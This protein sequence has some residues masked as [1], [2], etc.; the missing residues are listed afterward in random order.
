MR[1]ALKDVFHVLRPLDCFPQPAPPPPSPEEVYQAKAKGQPIATKPCPLE[2]LKHGA[3]SLERL[4]HMRTFTV[5]ELRRK[6]QRVQNGVQVLDLTVLKELKLV[7]SSLRVEIADVLGGGVGN[8]WPT[9]DY[10]HNGELVPFESNTQQ[11][12]FR[13]RAAVSTG[14][15]QGKWAHAVDL[16]EELEVIGGKKDADLNKEFSPERR[17]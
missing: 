6:L 10:M 15:G 12:D 3:K 5:S 17:A 13:P 11:L 8:G 16:H 14:C 4:V 9:P 2:T 7:A 1:P